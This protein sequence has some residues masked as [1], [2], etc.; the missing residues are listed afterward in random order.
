MEKPKTLTDALAAIDA[1]QAKHDGLLHANSVYAE[2]IQALEGKNA[3]MTAKNADLTAQLQ[4]KDTE[5]TELK[6]KVTTI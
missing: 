5:I 6:N 1:V 3:E 2:Q 4:E